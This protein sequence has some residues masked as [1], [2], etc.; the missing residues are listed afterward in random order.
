VTATPVSSRA[1]P[2]ASVSLTPMSI[3]AQL[4]EFHPSRWLSLS[5]AGVDGQV[6]AGPRRRIACGRCQHVSS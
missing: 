3:A 6:I 4:T 1:S 5:P 2:P